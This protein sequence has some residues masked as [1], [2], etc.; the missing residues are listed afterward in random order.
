MFCFPRMILACV[1]I[2]GGGTS[3]GY[4]VFLLMSVVYFYTVV[5]P[6]LRL[7]SKQLIS[8]TH[9]R[10]LFNYIY[11]YNLQLLTT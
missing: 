3:E 9:L 6:P 4:T 5:L 7:F 10:C 11:I 2:Y 8:S 1:E